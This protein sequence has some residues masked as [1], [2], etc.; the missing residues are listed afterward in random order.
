MMI[1]F[2][3][4][5]NGRKRRVTVVGSINYDMT[6]FLNSFPAPNQTILAQR[7]VSAMG[8]KGLNQA[9]AAAKLETDVKFIGKVGHDTFGQAALDYLKL[10]QVDITGIQRSDTPTGVATIFVNEHRENM[11]TVASGANS[12]LSPADIQEF[13]SLIKNADVLLV[14]LEVP[15]DCVAEALHIAKTHDVLT[16]LNPAPAQKDASDLF[17]MIDILTPNESEAAEFTGVYPKDFDSCAEAASLMRQQGGK[18]IVITLGKNGAFISEDG[19]E[20]ILPSFPVQ[21]VDPT[22]AGDVFNGILAARLAQGDTLEDAAVFASAGAAMSVTIQ[23]AEGAAPTEEEITD[24]LAQN[25]SG[26]AVN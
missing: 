11:I 3:K 7:S 14:Q 2:R 26:R 6:M 24:F 1:G 8:G 12:D 19:V 21:A 25:M 10:S 23:T 18:R 15:L 17:D 5:K 4:A 13:D 22:G 9:V 20:K 16:I